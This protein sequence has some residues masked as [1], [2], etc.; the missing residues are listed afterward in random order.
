[1]SESFAERFWARIDKDGPGGCWHWRGTIAGDGYGVLLRRQRKAHRVAY[2]LAVGPIPEG[3]T[4]DHLC[5]VRHCVNPAHLEPCTR[6]ENTL[7]APGLAWKLRAAQTHCK[8]GHEFTPENTLR[9]TGRRKCRTCTR[10]NRSRRSPPQR[11][12]PMRVRRRP[13]CACCAHQIETADARPGDYLCCP[14]CG[15]VNELM[16]ARRLRM[17]RPRELR[18]LPKRVLQAIRAAQQ[19]LTVL[20]PSQEVQP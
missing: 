14:Y 5:R 7:R 16:R 11:S 1:M 4:L 2:E 3:L 19:L 18:T 15:A 20:P 12:V 6:R 8:R 10:M 13:K 9:D 17:L